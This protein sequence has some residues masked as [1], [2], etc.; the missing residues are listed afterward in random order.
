MAFST[1]LL[2]SP[3]RKKNLARNKSGGSTL[4]RTKF[5]LEVSAAIAKIN[6][7]IG[8]KGVAALRRVTP[9][10]KERTASKSTSGRTKKGWNYESN[11]I[12]FPQLSFYNTENSADYFVFGTKK[13]FTIV[14]LRKRA[15]SFLS[16]TNYAASKSREGKFKGQNVLAKVVIPKRPSKI[17]LF[18]NTLK[19]IFSLWRRQVKKQVGRV[20]AVNTAVAVR[21]SLLSLSR[22]T[23]GPGQRTF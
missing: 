17:R 15:L 22:G 2:D 1:A 6:D 4:R 7:R 23:I 18:E 5:N 3:L 9:K 8:R 19:P 13:S 14:P 12:P 21:K 10:R 11:T 20:G 16:R